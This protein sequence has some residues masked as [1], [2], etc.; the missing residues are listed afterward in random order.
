[1]PHG[2]IT[3]EAARWCQRLD[4]A[5][6]KRQQEWEPSAK[7]N[8]DHY[9]G[10]WYT[11]ADRSAT[12]ADLIESNIAHADCRLL[13]SIVLN[14][15]PMIS[16][17]ANIPEDESKERLIEQILQATWRDG[18]IKQHLGRAVL[19]AIITGSGW[20]KTG[21][22]ASFQTVQKTKQTI[23]E[24]GSEV[25]LEEG[26]IQTEGDDLFLTSEAVYAVRISPF[27]ML[28]DP[29]A[30][31]ID[32]C[33]WLAQEIYRPIGDIYADERYPK[34]LRKKIRAT[35]RLSNGLETDRDHKFTYSEK[36]NP[37]ADYGLE[38][39][40]WDRRSDRYIVTADDLDSYL[41]YESIGMR[42]VSGELPFFYLYFTENPDMFFGISDIEIS[43]ALEIDLNKTISLQ[44]AAAKRASRL[45]LVPPGLDS[46]TKDRLANA[47]DGEVI[48][49]M[50]DSISIINTPPINSDVFN[51]INLSMSQIREVRGINE[52][53]RGGAPQAVNTA[54]EAGIIDYSSQLSTTPRRERIEEIS[55]D[56][57]RSL[58]QLIVAHYDTEHVVKIL[59]ANA[60]EE[61]MKWSGK[62]LEGKYRFSIE[63]GSSLPQ[64]RAAKIQ[65]RM[66][67]YQILTQSQM[68]PHLDQ[69]KIM[70]WL[71][72]AFDLNLQ[73]FLLPDNIRQ[74]MDAQIGTGMQSMPGQSPSGL[75]QNQLPNAAAPITGTNSSSRSGE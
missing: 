50:P 35:N 17:E 14:R 22:Q 8:L 61:W 33:R 45:F 56:I 15:M 7:K 74:Q 52:Y 40:I 39:H 37:E 3:S 20:I 53:M 72:S 16:V 12:T 36:I 47:E 60:T 67:I 51:G 9:R 46:T 59:S 18:K 73:T 48:E 19:D 57:T 41:L 64:Q 43:E 2:E 28:V 68:A 11:D 5:R 62:D 4:V 31:S 6:R 69:E 44:L 26:S 13:R 21:Y 75:P 49:S 1:M 66:V 42:W 70:R 58:W 71:L 25:L 65:E 54:T 30:T 10:N 24:D 34:D 55:A 29:S 63:A 38:L 23:G 27:S 32:S